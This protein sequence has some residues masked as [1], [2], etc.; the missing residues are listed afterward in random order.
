M[1]ISTGAIL[2]IVPFGVWKIIKQV[3]I[4]RLKMIIRAEYA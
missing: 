4:N 3:S 2:K 1:E